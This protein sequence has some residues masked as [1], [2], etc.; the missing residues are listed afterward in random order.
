MQIAISSG[1]GLH[2][3]GARGFLDEVDEAR[4]VA[5]HVGKILRELEVPV[6]VFH[7]NSAR[8]QRDNV[9]AIVRHHNS[10]N[11]DL[12]VSVHFNSFNPTSGFT[13]MDGWR[14]VDRAVGVEVL[15]RTNNT[16]TYNL[17]GHV[18]C[19]IS[20]ASGLLLRHQR[21]RGAVA[22][23]NIGFLNNT[24]A[25]AILIEV[26]FVNSREDK[27]LYMQ[28][29]ERICAAIACTVSRRTKMSA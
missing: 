11:R 7:E 4:R 15:Y 8:N 17:A 27:R 28:N 10:L 13:Q 3:R 22:R 21:D 24:T 9:N 5:D 16:K 29:F 2:V 1:H 12:D 14:A 20:D 18:A 25:P 6:N 19:S 23:S 26:C